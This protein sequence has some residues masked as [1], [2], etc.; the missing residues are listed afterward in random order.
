MDACDAG[1]GEALALGARRGRPG[2]AHLRQAGRVDQHVLARRRSKSCARALD[3]HRRRAPEGPRHPLGAR[4]GFI[5]GA[6]VEEFTRFKSPRGGAWRSCSAAG[7]CSSS[8]AA[9]PFPTI[10][11]VERLLHGRRRR[12]RARLPLPRRARRPEDALRAARS[13]ARH[14][15][16]RGTACKRLPKLV[17]AAAALDMLLTGKSVDARAREAH[18]PRRPGGAAAHPGERGAH[19]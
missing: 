6:D 19:A 17:G 11:M 12:A 1:A 14:H 15:A 13:D 3:A 4:N 18:R 10:A 7:T 5:A 8:C 16:R 2:V 9:L